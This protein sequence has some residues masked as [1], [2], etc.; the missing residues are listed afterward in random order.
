[1]KESRPFSWALFSSS[2]LS[3]SVELLRVVNVEAEL[4]RDDDDDDDSWK[5]RFD[6][7]SDDEVLLLT[8]PGSKDLTYLTL[9]VEFCC[10]RGDRWGQF[11]AFHM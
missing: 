11:E 7:D 4:N 8:D 6:S 1:M 3:E 9:P 10:N 2:S 5:L